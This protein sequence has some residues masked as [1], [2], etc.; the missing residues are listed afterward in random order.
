MTKSASL[1]TAIA[2]LLVSPA[3]FAGSEESHCNS[4]YSHGE[5]SVVVRGLGRAFL[6]VGER[7]AVLRRLRPGGG[8][9]ELQ[10]ADAREGVEEGAGAHLQR[11]GRVRAPQHVTVARAAKRRRALEAGVAAHD[12]LGL[13][14]EVVR[15]GGDAQP[16]AAPVG[17]GGV[18]RRQLAPG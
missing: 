12:T 13:E 14:H 15:R 7:R 5:K 18:V 3:I 6:S 1:P 8:Q 11:G 4:K 9:R 2:P 17:R 10:P 16:R